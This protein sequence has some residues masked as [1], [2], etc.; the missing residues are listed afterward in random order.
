MPLEYCCECRSISLFIFGNYILQQVSSS[1]YIFRIWDAFCESGSGVL[2]KWDL[3]FLHDDPVGFREVVK[4]NSSQVQQF[5]KLLVPH[6]TVQL[7][8]ISLVRL[9]ICFDNEK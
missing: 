8:F 5:D 3:E 2:A 6:G 4:P 7:I 9:S 1:A